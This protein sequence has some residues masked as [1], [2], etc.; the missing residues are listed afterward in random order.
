MGKPQKYRLGELLVQQGLVTEAQLEEALA[1][2]KQS[3]RK[4]GRVLV[5]SGVVTEE[6]IATAIARQLGIE[7]HDL[8]EK[9]VEPAVASVLPE[10]MARRFRALVLAD[11]GR[12]Y[13]VGM[14]DPSDV[15]GY[16]E[17]ARTLK[18]DVSLAVLAEG[19]LLGAI[20]RLY[21]RTH[22]ITGLANELQRDLGNA[23]VDFGGPAL[24][25]TADD[26][27]VV[28][29]L[30]S[31][32][33]DAF[34]IKASDVHIEP[35][36]L[37]LQIRFRIDGE[38]H[39]QT[40]VDSR[41]GPALVLRL[42]LMS[43]LDISEK[44]LPQDGRFNVKV[45]QQ[46]VDVRLST[47]PTQY[48]ESVV[49]RILAQNSGLLDLD[50]IGM[51]AEMLAHYRRMI[52][53]SY[54][55]ILVTG[56]TGSGKTTTLYA[57]LAALNAPST[58]IITIED[59]VEYRLPGLSQV[60]V[61]DKI[62]LSFARVLR[63]T[64]RHD[65][66]IVLVG[67]MIDQETAQIGVRAAMTGHL[68]LSTLHTNDAVSTPARLLDM[69]VPQY[70][71]ATTLL[72]VIAQ[73]LVR[74]ICP[75]C[76]TPASLDANEQ[77]WLEREAKGAAA[78]A[79]HGRGCSQCNN[80]GFAGREAIYEMLEMT[81]PLAEA[82]SRNSLADFSRLA[83]SQLAGKTMRAHAVAR[84]LAGETTVAEAMRVST[85]IDE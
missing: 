64:L 37:R 66:D 38:M 60:Q 63:S 27:P 52:S 18:K 19:Q 59:P 51:P 3:G 6:L 17:I 55:M 79:W 36:E 74:M 76:K 30:Q 9:D 70:L 7:F 8:R 54:G 5:E 42:K 68:L 47:M 32:F 41:V 62:E 29:L 48:G 53:H 77:I 78:Q 75:A 73:R 28:K 1:Q 12:S 61:N 69:G 83:R 33:E 23:Y 46:S 35:Q 40:E 21:R 81:P 65:P 31:I 44:R 22:E 13:L 45:K 10:T 82:L 56:P 71:L 34:Q 85:Q 25:T 16:D 39:L 24:E 43:G 15:F 58:K 2:Q 72:G 50:R 20:D 4:L 57:T 49:M 14:A 11:E 26:A 67:E 80:S 84:V